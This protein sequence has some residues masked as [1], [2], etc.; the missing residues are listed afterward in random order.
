MRRLA[1]LVI[2]ATVISCASSN[3]TLPQSLHC[4]LKFLRVWDAAQFA[5]TSL[6]GRIAHSDQTS[7]NILGRLDVDVFGFVVELNITVRRVPAH[8]P[9]TYEPVTVSVKA[10]EPGVPDPDEYH[11]EELRRLE[12]QYLDLVGGRAGCGSVAA[13]D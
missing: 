2:L 12:R 3:A 5:V 8:V 11:V 7:S 9:G 4:E 10:V 1:L 13:T 6:G